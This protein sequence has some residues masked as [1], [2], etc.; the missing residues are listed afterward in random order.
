ML[1]S[2][3]IAEPKRRRLAEFGNFAAR[4]RAV[5]DDSGL[6]DDQRLAKLH[7]LEQECPVEGEHA[8]HLLQGV[9][10]EITTR[11]FR[12]W[13]ELISWCGFA[14]A[15]MGR[16]AIDLHDE[17]DNA[18]PPVE[19][20][21]SALRLLHCVANCK[22]DFVERDRVYIPGDWLRRAGMDVMALGEGSAPAPLRPVFEQMLDGTDRLLSVARTGPVAIGDRGLRRAVVTTSMAAERWSK[23]LRRHDPLTGP[24]TPS[25]LDLWRARLR[26]KFAR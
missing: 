13:S 1:E 20:L 23:R 14:A 12:S 24:V 25:R 26:G 22:A 11:R 2:R 4:A 15:P 8:S 5:A 19:A 7:R 17:P 18:R 9:R 6:N 10:K 16:Y 21:F 3:N